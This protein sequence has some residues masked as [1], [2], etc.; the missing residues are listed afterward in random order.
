MPNAPKTSPS[1]AEIERMQS[2]EIAQLMQSKDARID[3]LMQKVE[4]LARQVDWFTRQHF[5]SRSERFIAQSDPSQMHLGEVF[6]PEQ[7]ASEKRKTIPAHTRRVPHDPVNE[8]AE[9]LPF[10]DESRGSGADDPPS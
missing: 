6:H 1:I 10:F 9:A 7:P 4:A 5:G 8:A 3:A 2:A